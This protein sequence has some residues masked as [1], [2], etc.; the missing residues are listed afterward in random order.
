MIKKIIFELGLYMILV[1]TIIGCLVTYFSP[2]L[3]VLTP[4]VTFIQIFCFGILM[5][6]LVT[7]IFTADN[8]R[9]TY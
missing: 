7:S 1:G 2:F 8:G 4:N 5:I 3:N 6:G 9:K